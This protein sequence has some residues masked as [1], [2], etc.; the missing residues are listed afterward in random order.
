MTDPEPTRVL[1]IERTLPHPPEKVW[2]ALTEGALLEEWLMRGDFQPV[3]GHSFTFHTTPRPPHFD[4]VIACRVLEVVPLARLTYTWSAVGVDTV[5]SYT[6]TPVAAG[7]L[8]RLEQQGLPSKEA[9]FQGAVYA[10]TRFLDGL[11]RLFSERGA[12]SEDE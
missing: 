8:L 1:V 2:R 10:W 9:N 6:L 4:G 7:T 5:V 11:E 12:K 3:V